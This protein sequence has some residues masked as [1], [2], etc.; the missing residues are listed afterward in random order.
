MAT[1]E[2]VETVEAV[3]ADEVVKGRKKGM[4]LFGHDKIYKTADEAKPNEPYYQK[5]I[6]TKDGDKEY[7]SYEGKFESSGFKLYVVEHIKEKW[8]KFV[9]SRTSDSAV[10]T[11]A[12]EF[13][14]AELLEPGQRGRA[15]KIDP[16]YIMF[17]E[18]MIEQKKIP[19]LLDTIKAQELLHY[20]PFLGLD[21]NGN[22]VEKKDLPLPM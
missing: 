20:L 10:A 17:F 9:W 11:V 14:Q 22:Q 12:S 4:K 2:A 3:E 19:K 18:S 16:I 5:E 8:E 6:T 7:T 1:A 13:M 21:E 15:R